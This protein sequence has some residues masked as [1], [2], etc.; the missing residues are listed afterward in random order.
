MSISESTTETSEKFISKLLVRRSP[1]S[2]KGDNGTVAVVGGSAIYHGAPTLAGL[3]AL[4][5][6]VDLVYLGVPRVV[7]SSIRAITP[8]LIVLPLPD[9]KLTVGCVN[10]LLKW[11]PKVGTILI[12]PGAGRQRTDGM[13][14]IVAE[15]ASMNTSIVIDADALMKD[16][17]SRANILPSVITPHAGEFQRLFGVDLNEDLASLL[18][19]VRKYSELAG[20]TI[21]LKGS[22]DIISNGKQTII[23]RTGSPSM[24][25]GGT[26]DV[27]AGL[28]SGF[29]AKGM[30]P[31]NAAAAGAYVNGIAGERATSRLG[32]HITATDVIEELAQ[33]LKRLDSFQDEE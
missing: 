31:L 30:S 12:G 32:F 16:V 7:S 20:T 21:L 25:V 6:G 26:G 13:K 17:V 19:T 29:L 8:N 18:Q 33:V 11:L 10:K 9:S 2:H 15:A 14:R 1:N 22:V 23:N 4:R 3:A 5:A 27:L 28:V 24:T